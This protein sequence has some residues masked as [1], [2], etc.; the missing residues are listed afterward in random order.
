MYALPHF[1]SNDRPLCLLFS[2]RQ[3]L[4]NFLK[5]VWTGTGRLSVFD[6]VVYVIGD[7]FSV[8][9]ADTPLKV[10]Q[11]KTFPRCLMSQGHIWLMHIWQRVNDDVILYRSNPVSCERVNI[12]I[13]KESTRNPTG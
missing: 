11:S 6:Y 7:R 13:D 10:R 4:L 5:S 3:T 9:I 8:V 2:I 1:M 12:G